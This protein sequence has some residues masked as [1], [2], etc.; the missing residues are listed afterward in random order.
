MLT[1]EFF[2][3]ALARLSQPLMLN[4]LSAAALGLAGLVSLLYAAKLAKLV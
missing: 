2:R 3:S 1:R 4:I